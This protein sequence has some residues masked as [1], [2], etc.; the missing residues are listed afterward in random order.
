[1]VRLRCS[2]SQSIARVREQQK[3]ARHDSCAPA[4]FVSTQPCV[5]GAVLSV[6]DSR[7]QSLP[8]HG[9]HE[10][11]AA[12]ICPRHHLSCI[13]TTFRLVLCVPRWPHV[14]R[15]CVGCTQRECRSNGDLIAQTSAALQGDEDWLDLFWISVEVLRAGFTCRW[16]LEHYC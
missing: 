9:G 14:A 16:N 15:A 3:A 13:R 12:L 10:C 4:L 7:E 6:A 8:A 11:G 1:M 5:A 2:L